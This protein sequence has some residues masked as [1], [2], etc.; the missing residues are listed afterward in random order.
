MAKKN[1]RVAFRRV[2]G[3]IVPIKIKQE[4]A[5]GK[6]LAKKGGLQSLGIIAGSAALGLGS[7]FGAGRLMRAANKLGASGKG[8]K[9]F[10]VNKAAKVAKFGGAFVPGIITAR[11]VARL[12]RASRKDEKSALFNIGKPTGVGIAAA[13]AGGFAYYRLGK[14]IEVFGFTKKFPRKLRDL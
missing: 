6:D 4:I 5:A 8:R 13:A 9:A 3:R 11:E 1:E 10:A 7:L 2:R 14:R 12:D